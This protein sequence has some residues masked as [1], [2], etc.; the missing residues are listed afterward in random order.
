MIEAQGHWFI[1]YKLAY[2]LGLRPSAEKP[3]AAYQEHLRNSV[4]VS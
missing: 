2:S 3:Y 4:A 1:I